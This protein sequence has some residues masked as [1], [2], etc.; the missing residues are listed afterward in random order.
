MIHDLEARTTD[1]CIDG[2]FLTNRMELSAALS[3][4]FSVKVKNDGSSSVLIEID[5]CLKCRG[6]LAQRDFT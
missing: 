4:V 1:R 5:C 2:S 6:T 3:V